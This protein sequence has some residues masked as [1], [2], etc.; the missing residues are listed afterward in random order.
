MKFPLDQFNKG[1]DSEEIV[2]IWGEMGVGKTT[3]ALQI[4][5]NNI[6]GGDSVYYFYSKPRLP[7]EKIES[8]LPTTDPNS[9]KKLKTILIK[10][11]ND[12][13][14]IVLDLEINILK[15]KKEKQ[16]YPKLII[17]DSLTDLYRLDLYKDKKEK[18]LILNYK[19]NHL[20]GTLAHIHNKFSVDILVVNEISYLRLEDHSHEIQSGGKVMRYW[21]PFSIKIA[22]S[23]I[24][25]K[26]RL[27]LYK[28]SQI[29][30]ERLA[31]LSEKGF[32]TM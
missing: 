22:R 15:Y 27:Y 20:L 2:S 16:D 12:L 24:M 10:N 4:A 13:Y 23:E 21:F 5:L 6:Q 3:L 32:L 17:I 11:F 14:R 25:N 30:F 18:N 8:L 19:L 31:T 7:F 9:L 26:R 28:N 1:I 29:Q